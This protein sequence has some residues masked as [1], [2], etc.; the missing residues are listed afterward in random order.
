VQ[1]Q[2]KGTVLL[3]A[4]ILQQDPVQF[5]SAPEYPA[6]INLTSGSEIVSENSNIPKKPIKK[7]KAPKNENEATGFQHDTIPVPPLVWKFRLDN[8]IEVVITGVA[9]NKD[10]VLVF[11]PQKDRV[12]YR[13]DEL[14]ENVRPKN[15]VPTLYLWLNDTEAKAIYRAIPEKGKVVL[16]I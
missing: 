3:E 1:V 6:Y 4:Q 7:V 14:K 12:R 15:Y 9:L 13:F 11:T 10:S 16:K 2:L 8:E 5:I